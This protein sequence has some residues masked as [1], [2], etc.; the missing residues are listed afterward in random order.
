MTSFELQ[1]KNTE[2]EEKEKNEDNEALISTTITSLKA[3]TRT[4]ISDQIVSIEETSN[5][6][7]SKWKGLKPN[8]KKSRN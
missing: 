6:K 1:E 5:V 4:T 3:R 8:K 7:S 2:E